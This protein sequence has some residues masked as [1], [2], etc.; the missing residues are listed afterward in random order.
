[1]STKIGCKYFI[2]W[3][4]IRMRLVLEYNWHETA[5]FTIQKRI[6]LTWENSLK[7]SAW[8]LSFQNVQN[9]SV[10]SKFHVKMHYPYSS[11]WNKHWRVTFLI[12]G[13][14]HSIAGIA[15]LQFK[16]LCRLLRS[17]GSVLV[18]IWLL[19]LLFLIITFCARL[20]TDTLIEHISSPN[21][22]CVSG[23]TVCLRLRK[24][25]RALSSIVGYHYVFHI[26]SI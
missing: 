1:M 12:H 19:D 20:G 17:I 22:I 9:L 25:S 7:Y 4:H 2:S 5:V 24:K 6:I 11:R 21:C 26:F 14:Q 13:I 15:V 3:K 16:C 8:Q 18:I 10:E 23:V